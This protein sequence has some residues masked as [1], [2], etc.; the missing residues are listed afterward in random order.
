MKDKLKAILSK[1]SKTLVNEV[2][3]QGNLPPIPAGVLMPIY[4]KDNEYFLIFTLRTDMVEHHK[5]QISFPGG[6]FHPD[7]ENLLDTALRESFE[8]IGLWPSD[9]LVVGELDDLITNSNFCVTPF[10]GFIPYPYTF[11]TSKAEVAEIIHAPLSMLLDKRYFRQEK[12]PNGSIGY[13]YN[14]Q[15]YIIWGVT[16]RIL[17]PFLDIIVSEGLYSHS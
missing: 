14:C 7:D 4:Q 15:G 8:E 3:S 17:K 11:H 2:P 12:R 6:A 16:A 9:V 5:G 10:V 13:Y 1:R